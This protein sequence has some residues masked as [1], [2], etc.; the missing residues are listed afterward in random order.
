[1]VYLPWHAPICPERAEL[2]EGFVEMDHKME[3]GFLIAPPF[4]NCLKR[5]VEGVNQSEELADILPPVSN[6]VG[7]SFVPLLS[8]PFRCDPHLNE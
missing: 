3:L 4:G 1:M 2:K 7:V 6:S 8:A 5:Y